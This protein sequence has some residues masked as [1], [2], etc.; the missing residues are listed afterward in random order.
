MLNEVN[1]TMQTEYL[2][3]TSIEYMNENEFKIYNELWTM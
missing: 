1:K 2:E 3:D